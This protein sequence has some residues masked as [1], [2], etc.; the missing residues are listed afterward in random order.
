[1]SLQS[2]LEY[3][4]EYAEKLEAKRD[5]QIEAQNSIIFMQNETERL[6]NK[7]KVCTTLALLSVIGILFLAFMAFT[8][9]AAE[10]GEGLVQLFGLL[11]IAIAVFAVS[12]FKR[13]QFKNEYNDF[14]RKK[15]SL[16]Q[17]YTIEAENCQREMAR[18]IKKIYYEDLFDIVPS[19]YFSVAAIE[20]C[21]SQVR[22]KLANSASEAFRQLEAEIK[23]LE[24]MEYLEELS[25]AHMEQLN[26]IKR[27][28][29]I[30]T[31]ITMA[32]QDKRKNS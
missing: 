4:L 18:I 1:M 17:Q 12:F 27:A 13:I 10:S 11:I 20:F 28:I 25:N 31:L 24:Q 15:P 23:R 6:K 26:D 9:I 19:D 30:N 3:C 21:L 7:L 29:E 8:F 5:Q 32:E 16:I 14:E 22:K 2:D